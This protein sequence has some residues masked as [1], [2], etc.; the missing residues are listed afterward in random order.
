MFLLPRTEKPE[1]NAWKFQ[2]ML[3]YNSYSSFIEGIKDIQ[4]MSL[5]KILDFMPY[6]EITYLLG[7]NLANERINNFGLFYSV[8][9][10]TE[11]LN[12]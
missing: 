12:Y 5:E 10:G 4:R 8:K 7:K 6:H 2:D 1:E 3:D 11:T 9:A